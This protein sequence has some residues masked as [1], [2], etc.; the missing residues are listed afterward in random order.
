VS[1]ADATPY[2]FPPSISDGISFGGHMYTFN[3]ATA[4]DGK[5]DPAIFKDGG[6]PAAPLCIWATY[7]AGNEEVAFQG[8]TADANF[9]YGLLNG[10]PEGLFKC[11]LGGG[12]GV[13]LFESSAGYAHFG[14]VDTGTAL[15]WE[16]FNGTSEQ[17][18][19][20]VK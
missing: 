7:S 10:G 6:P 4:P 8:M 5:Q 13:T 20:L 12:P 15:Y 1:G 19:R 17:V 16:V 3:Y 18:Y 11:P 2:N 9:V 14:L